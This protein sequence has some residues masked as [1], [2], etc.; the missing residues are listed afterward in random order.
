MGDG[1][2]AIRREP[3]TRRDLVRN[4]RDKSLKRGSEPVGKI[5]KSQYK[6]LHVECQKSPSCFTLPQSDLTSSSSFSNLFH[7]LLVFLLPVACSECFSPCFLLSRTHTIT[8]VCYCLLL[9]GPFCGT[10]NRRLVAVA[11]SEF[12]ESSSF[13]FFFGGA[14]ST[15]LFFFIL[16]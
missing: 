7:S 4:L 16:L 1:A 3:A 11:S 9:L 10:A 15:P 13:F 14:T 12:I 6:C 8:I 5:A 2:G